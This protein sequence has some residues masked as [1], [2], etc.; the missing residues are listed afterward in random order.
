MGYNSPVK[1]NAL[2]GR[3]HVGAKRFGFYEVA[4]VDA[5]ARDNKYLH[6]VLL[7]Y[8]KGKNPA[9]DPSQVLRDYVVQ[10]D[11]KN[12]DLFLGKAYAALGPLRIPTNFFILE[13][14]RVGLTAY[15]KR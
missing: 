5:T 12:P 3:W 7:D 13:R 2:D 8:G 6:A 14:F 11:A 4:P 10:V 9:Y 1:N 15:V